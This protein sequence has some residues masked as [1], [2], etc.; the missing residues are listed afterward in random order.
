MELFARFSCTMTAGDAFID[1][2]A[3]LSTSLN[4]QLMVFLEKNKIENYRILNGETNALPE[5]YFT[6]RAQTVIC[7]MFI[8]YILL[9]S[10]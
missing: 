7:S 1:D 2:D 10:K 6:A 8:A 9:K 3:V 4:K 5:P